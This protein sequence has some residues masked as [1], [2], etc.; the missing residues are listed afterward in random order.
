MR[1]IFFT[2]LIISTVFLHAQQP[3]KGKSCESSPE[4]IPFKSNNNKYGYLNKKGEVVIKPQYDEA[5]PFM[6]DFEIF[7][8]E[9]AKQ[10]GKK[11]YATVKIDQKHFRINEFKYCSK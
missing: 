4:L 8:S 3:N 9:N 7:N 11:E 10:F 5:R 2:F 6:F 1:F